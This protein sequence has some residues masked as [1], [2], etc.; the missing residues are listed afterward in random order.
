RLTSSTGISTAI[1][2]LV[3]LCLV[4]LSLVA[5]SFVLS[6]ISAGLTITFPVRQRQQSREGRS[7]AATPCAV[8][9]SVKTPEEQRQTAEGY[10]LPTKVINVTSGGQFRRT[11]GNTTPIP[12][13]V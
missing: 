7:S 4:V 9:L 8:S 2:R 11:G 5:L 6:L 3:A 1:S 12:R 13:L 10:I